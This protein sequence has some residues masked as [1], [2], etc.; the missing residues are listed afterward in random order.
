MPH[1]ESIIAKVKAPDKKKLDRS[2]PDPTYGKLPQDYVDFCK[3]YGV[4]FFG[5]ESQ[6]RLI[7]NHNPFS[8]NFVKHC[9]GTHKALSQLRENEGVDFVPYPIFPDPD[10][11]FCWGDGA[12]DR[13]YFWNCEGDPD[14]WCVIFRNPEEKFVET[15]MKTV[16]FLYNVFVGKFDLGAGIGELLENGEEFQFHKMTN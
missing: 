4:G 15:G 8:K 3:W 14:E 1:L 16:E 10:G 6:P 2:K 7:Q 12:T 13:I 5:I 9:K 11:L